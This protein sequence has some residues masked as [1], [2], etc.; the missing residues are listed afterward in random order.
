[1]LYCFANLSAEAFALPKREL[2][3]GMIC[4]D[5]SSTWSRSVMQRMEIVLKL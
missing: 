1:M 4:R 5:S 2:K 3:S